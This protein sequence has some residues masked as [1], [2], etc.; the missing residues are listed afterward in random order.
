MVVG[1]LAVIYI[2]AQSAG[3]SDLEFGF[4]VVSLLL[5]IEVTNKYCHVLIGVDIEGHLFALLNQN[6]LQACSVM[7]V[8]LIS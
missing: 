5:K 2:W 7:I 4:S 3:N 6:F 8:F 1:G